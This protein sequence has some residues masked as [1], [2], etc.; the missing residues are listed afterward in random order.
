SLPLLSVDEYGVEVDISVAIWSWIIG[1][2]F[3]VLVGCSLAEICS[4]YPSAGSV[5]HWAGQLVPA[6]NAPLASFIC[7]WFNFIGNS[8]G[9]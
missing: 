6:R 3:T 8:A 2:F 1:S 7:G 9:K 4:V 5:Y